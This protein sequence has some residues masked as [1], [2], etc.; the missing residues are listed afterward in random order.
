MARNGAEVWQKIHSIVDEAAARIGSIPEIRCISE[1]TDADGVPRKIERSRLLI[2]AWEMGIG[3]RD[4]ADLLSR[5]YHIDVE[6]ADH[7]YII[8]TAG[9]GTTERE[10]LLLESALQEISAAQRKSAAADSGKQNPE[11]Q[12]GKLA[13]WRAAEYRA[14]PVSPSPGYDPAKGFFF[15]T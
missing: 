7:L 14:G 9:S 13:E 5:R 8:A 10:F 15:P 12:G 2:S 4:L 3:G 11:E 6:F 1:Y